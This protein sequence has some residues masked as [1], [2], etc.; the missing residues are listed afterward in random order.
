MIKSTSIHT[1][2]AKE[3]MFPTWHIQISKSLCVSIDCH[4]KRTLKISLNFFS[5][6]INNKL[7]LH[8]TYSGTRLR[9]ADACL[10]TCYV[11]GLNFFFF[12]FF[13]AKAVDI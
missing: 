4:K 2:L 7:L 8:K 9:V 13:S 10:Y 1:F 5:V 11:S 12:F 6:E 3:K